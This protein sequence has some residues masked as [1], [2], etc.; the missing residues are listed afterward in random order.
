[1]LPILAA[2]G[3]SA[4]STLVGKAATALIEQHLGG[5]TSTDSAKSSFATILERSQATKSTRAHSK[6]LDTLAVSS[7]VNGRAEGASLGRLTTE[8]AAQRSLAPISGFT[9][10]P[11]RPVAIQRSALSS[12]AVQDQIG[13]QVTAN[14]SVI[15]L[16]GP[17]PPVLRYRLPSAAGSAYVEVRDLQGKI[18]RRVELGPQPGG[19]H[20]QYFDGRGLQSGLYTYKVIARDTTGLPIACASTASGRVSGVRL[21]EGQAFLIVGSSL[22]PLMSVAGSDKLKS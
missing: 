3:I 21:E 1:M 11:Q 15:D 14:G 10:A 18:V 13:R 16:R 7:L 20:E 19:V 9:A 4:L 12:R 22:V 5:I 2:I 17:I 6:G 8:L